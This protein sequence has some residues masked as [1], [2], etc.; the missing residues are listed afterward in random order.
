MSSAKIILIRHA[1][2][3]KISG[4]LPEYDPDAIIND[5]HIKILAAHIPRD[6]TWYV[7]PLK[8]TIQPAKA[9]SKYVSYK[10]MNLEKNLEEQNFGD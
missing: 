3:R 8:R 7:S 9:L 5:I 6:S 4:S 2:A 10:E 1:P